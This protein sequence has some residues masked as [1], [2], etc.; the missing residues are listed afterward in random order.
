MMLE[1]WSD[2]WVSG[3]LA[4]PD[5]SRSITPSLSRGQAPPIPSFHLSR[6][7]VFYVPAYPRVVVIGHIEACFCKHQIET[8][9]SASCPTSYHN[10]VV[11]CD[12][13]RFSQPY[14][15]L[16]WDEGR[17]VF[18]V[19]RKRPVDSIRNVTR[20]QNVLSRNNARILGVGS[21][22][23]DEVVRVTQGVGDVMVGGQ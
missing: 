1:L 19:P 5:D 9:G 17:A 14:E 20:I 2:T 4:L 22:I 6:Q 18:E 10:P 7:I 11:P 23:Y 15:L 16:D 12:S 3:E 21:G 13:P 8:T